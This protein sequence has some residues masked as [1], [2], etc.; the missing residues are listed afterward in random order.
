MRVPEKGAVVKKIST[1]SSYPESN[2]GGFISK[3]R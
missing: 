3:V 1:G 2:C